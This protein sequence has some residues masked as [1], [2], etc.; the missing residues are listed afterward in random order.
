[1]D[2]A[3]L[4][5][6]AGVVTHRVVFAASFSADL[7]DW[8]SR[9]VGEGLVSHPICSR[10][11]MCNSAQIAFHIPSRFGTRLLPKCLHHFEKLI[12]VL[13]LHHEFDNDHQL[14]RSTW[15]AVSERSYAK[16]HQHGSD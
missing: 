6:R 14:T 10:N 5:R 3:A 15:L 4:H 2:L 8:L 12:A 13:R 7:T 9:T 16:Y 11:A 1:V